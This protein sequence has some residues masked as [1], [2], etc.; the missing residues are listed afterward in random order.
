MA[1]Y[2]IEMFE[3]EIESLYPR[4][5]RALTVYLAG[6]RVEPED[7][8]QETFIKAF[9]NLHQFNGESG[10]YTWL[11][12]IARNLSID[13]FRKQK[14]EKNRSYIPVDEFELTSDQ[15]LS[16]TE[17][18]EVLLLRKAISLLPEKLRSVVIMKSIDQMSYGE[19]SEVT[20]INEQTLR[21]RMFRA[22]KLLAESLKKM[23]I[24]HK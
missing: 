15:Y 2:S 12:S 13:E 16:D 14:H 19:I 23:G 21:N 22:K 10:I 5:N 7:I 24:D 1:G 8:L 18:E 3:K 6:S 20:G 9:R 11:F 4:L 17:R